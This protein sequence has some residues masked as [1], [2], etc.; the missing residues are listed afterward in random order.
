MS[1]FTTLARPYARAVYQLA[2]ASSTV[3][4]WGDALALLSMVSSDA[5]MVAI[6][7]SPQLGH[8]K[9][10]EQIYQVATRFYTDAVS[11]LSELEQRN[12]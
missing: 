11:L 5:T 10:A 6:I 1:D 9:K 3:D 8:E 12:A 2:Q 7:D 4:A